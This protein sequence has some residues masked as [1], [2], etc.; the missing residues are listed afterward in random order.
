MSPK[1]ELWKSSGSCNG[2]T[3]D[4]QRSRQQQPEPD[5]LGLIE[6]S[7]QPVPSYVPSIVRQD[8]DKCSDTNS[9]ASNANSF[10]LTDTD[11]INLVHH[12]D[13]SPI[14]HQAFLHPN[15]QRALQG[16][17]DED[18]Y[19]RLA[20]SLQLPRGQYSP[21]DRAAMFQGSDRDYNSLIAQ[22]PATAYFSEVDRVSF[23]SLPH[24]QAKAA[25]VVASETNHTVQ[26]VESSI[27]NGSS[28]SPKD[29]CEDQSEA[30]TLYTSSVKYDKD[31]SSPKGCDCERGIIVIEAERKQWRYQFSRSSIV[32]ICFAVLVC[33][34]VL[35]AFI[36]PRLPLFQI[37][38]SSLSYSPQVVRNSAMTKY[39]VGWNL[40]V[41]VD[42]RNNYLPTSIVNMD[43]FARHSASGI[44]YNMSLPL[45]IEYESKPDDPVMHDIFAA[46]GPG[47]RTN[48]THVLQVHFGVKVSIWGLSYFGYNPTVILTPPAG[49]YVCPYS[50]V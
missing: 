30:N 41:S 38:G 28:S 14:T 23:R 42:N 22:S 43:I 13:H 20:S 26:Y 24:C 15:Q 33:L 4:E 5:M 36:W 8:H 39:A 9:M 35:L 40:D 7:D 45:N 2:S 16:T 32:M 12:V 49:G 48:E 29:H 3:D 11:T 27:K 25:S 1:S 21:L 50:A 31:E 34:S 18:Y 46:C 17:M 6:T 37:S 44:I 19:E 47:P 10:L